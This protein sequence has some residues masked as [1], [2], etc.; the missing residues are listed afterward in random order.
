MEKNRVV[1]SG[2]TMGSALAMIL[3]WSVNESIGYAILHGFCG[4]G[5]VLYFVVI[6]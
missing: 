3:S 2:L 6:Q 1:D 4:W 5:Y